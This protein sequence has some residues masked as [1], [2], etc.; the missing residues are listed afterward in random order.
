MRGSWLF[1]MS[2]IYGMALMIIASA[3]LSNS[4]LALSIIRSSI[5]GENVDVDNLIKTRKFVD[6]SL[7]FAIIT[8]IVGTVMFVMH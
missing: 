1:M 6:K 4:R 5:N 2:N 8:A 7:I 3:M